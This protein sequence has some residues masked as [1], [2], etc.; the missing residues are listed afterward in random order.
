MLLGNKVYTFYFIYVREITK[1]SGENTMIIA[2]L[3][4]FAGLTS[5][6]AHNNASRLAD[7]GSYSRTGGNTATT[8]SRSGG[9]T[10]SSEN[11]TVYHLSENCGEIKGV[12]YGDHLGGEKNKKAK[13]NNTTTG[14]SRGTS[15]PFGRGSSLSGSDSSSRR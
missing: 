2:A 9:T 1:N 4:F 5:Q 14:G 12:W 11:N 8:G 3:A 13:S 7:N 15:N 6:N 10:P